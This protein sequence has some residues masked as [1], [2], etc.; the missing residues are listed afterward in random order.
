MRTPIVYVAGPYR[1]V[2]PG[3]VD[4]NIARAREVGRLVASAGA[5]PFIPHSNTAH[6]D[7]LAPD[8][9]FL[10]GTLRLLAACDAVVLCPGWQASKGT[11]AERAAASGLRM[12][13]LNLERIDDEA[14]GEAIAVLVKQLQAAR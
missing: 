14:H 9:V 10:E 4:A 6:F 8:S 5:Y 7:G 11:V 1:A 13:I 12:P 2:C 3:L